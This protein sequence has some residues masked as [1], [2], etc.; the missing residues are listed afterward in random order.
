MNRFRT[1]SIKVIDCSQKVSVVSLFAYVCTSFFKLEPKMQNLEL[2]AS[3]TDQEQRS[4]I[5]FGVHL[6]K[7]SEVFFIKN[8]LRHWERHGLYHCVLLS[9]GHPIL[10]ADRQHLLWTHQIRQKT[11][12]DEANF[13][14]FEDLLKEPKS[15][16]AR[17]LA[18]L[19]GIRYPSFESLETQLDVEIRILNDG[20]T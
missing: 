17:E 16:S 8:W 12:S 20:H 4:Y 11:A 19:M 10:G 1:A 6:K 2:I 5:K 7:S 13:D 18:L 3:T 9:D 15:W 14:Q